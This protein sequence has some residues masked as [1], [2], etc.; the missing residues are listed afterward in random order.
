MTYSDERE[1]VQDEDQEDLATR[2]PEFCFSVR[3][4]SQDIASTVKDDDSGADGGYGNIIPPVLQ[5]KVKRGDF[6]RDQQSLVEEK[7]PSSHEACS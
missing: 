5:N 3:F 4:D 1:A 7:I 2:E 6:E